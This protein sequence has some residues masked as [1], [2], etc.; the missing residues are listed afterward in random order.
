MNTRLVFKMPQNAGFIKIE[1]PPEFK[2]E[3]K[4]KVMTALRKFSAGKKTRT[5]SKLLNENLLHLAIYSGECVDCLSINATKENVLRGIFLNV[6]FF[7]DSFGSEGA[8]RLATLILELDKKIQKEK[9]FISDAQLLN[10]EELQKRKEETY[11]KFL[12][13]LDYIKIVDGVY[14]AFLIFLANIAI[15]HD[16]Q[17]KPKI[18]ATTSDILSAIIKKIYKKAG[19]QL[20]TETHQLIDAIA[21]YFIR[22]YFYGDTSSYVINILKRAFNEDVINSIQK[23]KVTRFKEFGDIAE[24]LSK[25]GLL[26]ITKE[27]FDMEMR[28]M[29]G[30]HAYETYISKALTTFTAFMAN[31]ANSTSIFKNAYEVEPEL[32]ERLEQ[33]LLNEQKKIILKGDL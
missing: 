11:Q 5:V 9:Q 20:D 4:K 25:T 21:I 15:L 26:P 30:K 19:N 18:I 32:H 8:V 29:F 6:A 1:L 2:E 3:F 14:F 27:V 31:L 13:S 28:R 7:D 24:I 12:A 17:G 22:V 23:S 16:P 33:L 10:L